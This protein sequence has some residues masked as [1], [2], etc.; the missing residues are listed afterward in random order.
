MLKDINVIL[1]EMKKVVSLF[2]DIVYKL[3]NNGL[4]IKNIVL[5]RSL[6]N[7]SKQFEEMYSNKVIADNHVGLKIKPREKKTDN[8]LAYSYFIDE[9]RL[10][11]FVYNLEQ[12][13]NDL[14][15]IWI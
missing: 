2:L 7:V 1:E 11:K 3:K 13:I 10:D 12:D 14:Y 9:K 4:K 5:T 6:E 15:N 8:V